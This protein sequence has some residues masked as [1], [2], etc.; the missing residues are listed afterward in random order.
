MYNQLSS[1][2]AFKVAVCFLEHFYYKTSSDDLGSLLG[3]MQLLEDGSGT[4]DSAAWHDWIDALEGKL[5]VTSYEAFV[6]TFNFLNAYHTR[7]SSSSVDIQSLLDEMET[8][9]IKKTINA[10]IWQIWM[11]CTTNVMNQ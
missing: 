6:V 9:K 7:T 10:T 5:S 2:Q 8:Y 3:D 11:S 4:W 1:L